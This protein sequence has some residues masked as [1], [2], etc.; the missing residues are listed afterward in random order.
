MTKQQYENHLKAVQPGRRRTKQIELKVE[1]PKERLLA[2]VRSIARGRIKEKNAKRELAEANLR[3]VVSIA[4]NI[5]IVG[6]SFLTLS[7]KET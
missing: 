2:T 4:K 1:T 6:Y 5:P 7:K 3:L